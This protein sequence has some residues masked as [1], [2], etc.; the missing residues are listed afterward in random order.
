M[1]N[2]EVLHLAKDLLG[3]TLSFNGISLMITE[4]E[5]Y[6]GSDDQASHAFKRT[7][8]SEIMFGPSYRAYVYQIHTHHCLN[9]V[10]GPRSQGA[11]VLLRAGVITA[12]LEKVLRN[13]SMVKPEA[14][15]ASG[16]GNL[17][18]SLGV[19]IADK[20]KP[21][22]RLDS[23]LSAQ[24][25]LPFPYRQDF[26]PGEVFLLQGRTRTDFEIS[27]GPRVGVRLAAMQP[28]RFWISGH[29]SVSKYKLHPKAQSFEV[30]PG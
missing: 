14:K 8:R 13:H 10:T 4:V 15:L 21:V 6:N 12:G 11:A 30:E 18:R 17:A 9:I 23:P 29:P 20:G 25:F 1:P 26:A 3:Q 24:E 5:A 22:I 2:P 16:P 28:W 27:C 7:K 19:S